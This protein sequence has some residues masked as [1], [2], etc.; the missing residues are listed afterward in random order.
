MAD[1]PA[2]KKGFAPVA[3]EAMLAF[4]RACD[5]QIEKGRQK[6]GTLLEAGNGRNAYEDCAQEFVDAW[7]Y[8]TQARMEHDA[9]ADLAKDSLLTLSRAIRALG[10]G[11]SV[12]P[13]LRAKLPLLKARAE[14]LGIELEGE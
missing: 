1:Q 14:V 7:M 10:A 6:Y 13:G 2:P 4:A 9:L 12:D 3:P 8:L 11:D 5:S